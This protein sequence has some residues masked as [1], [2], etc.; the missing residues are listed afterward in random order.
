MDKFQFEQTF[1]EY[2]K[3]ER[4][5]QAA[6]ARALHVSRSTVSKWITGENRVAYETLFEI[7]ELLE[8]SD[9]ER[10]DFFTLAGYEFFLHNQESAPTQIASPYPTLHAE[11]KTYD[12]TLYISPGN[13]HKP[14]QLIGRDSQITQLCDHLVSGDHVLLTGYGGTG[15]TAL[16]ATVADAR[17]EATGK[18]VLWLGADGDDVESF[19]EALLAPFDAQ[20]EIA[21][22]RDHA[23][24]HAVQQ[25]LAS[26]DLALVVLDDLTHIN[27]L[28][29]LRP[30][31]PPGVPLLVTSRQ[32]AANI[33]RVVRLV[34]LQPA[35]AVN[36]LA[37]QAQ[38]ARFP[39]DEYASDPDT[40]RLC[41]LLGYHPLG[42]VI[43]GAWLKQ[44]GRAAGDLLRRID[45]A[46]ASA[47]TLEMPPGFAEA[48]RETV[49][50][51]LDQT[52]KTF[53]PKARGALRAF[54]SLHAPRATRDLLAACLGSESD[55]DR[56]A[57]DDALDELT[58][59]NFASRET[60]ED[61][62]SELLG[63]S[64]RDLPTVFTLHDMIYDYARLL[65]QRAPQTVTPLA[66][67]AQ[68]YVQASVAGDNQEYDDLKVNLPNVLRAAERADDATCLA[69]IAPI[70]IDGYMD[71]RGHRLDLLALLDRAIAYLQAQPAL[72]DAASRQLHHLLSKRGNAYFDRADYPN[73]VAAYR[74]ALELAYTFQREVM[75]IALV[76]KA[77]S[78][79][80]E[81]E[82]AEQHFAE[83]TGRAREA[84][85][86]YSLSF[87]L[88]QHAHVTIQ[89]E[90]YDHSHRITTEQ[91]AVNER[92]LKNEQ[93]SVAHQR[94]IF[95]LIMLGTSFIFGSKSKTSERQALEK[96]LEV[97]LRANQ[98][99]L[100]IENT[101][102]MAVSFWAVGDD[103]SRLGNSKRAEESFKLA[104]KLYSLQGKM[105]IARK[106]EHQILES[107]HRVK[108]RLMD[109]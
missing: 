42:L 26:A 52:L 13:L 47:L 29:Q 56:W 62:T 55:S 68:V 61:P 59:W 23:R 75:L 78:F 70:A 28:A 100:Q 95:S 102:A 12:A 103:Y 63:L 19:F 4:Y 80:G 81:V 32:D 43:A 109:M 64:A 24:T 21:D 3:R 96:A 93:S 94:L 92:I 85:D 37:G 87:V 77:L 58:A 44:H 65:H 53:S 101:H 20:S 39:R 67:A 33:D 34:N 82:A 72:D 69:L 22:K 25:T 107:N 6:L 15:K 83:A 50:F 35:A 54:G 73:A 46:P 45:G 108:E 51:T 8:L 11:R 91:V 74:A 84:G 89:C 17:I 14:S 104:Q 66:E 9:G 97:H 49:K 106:I 10:I 76:G 88:E 27:F 105:H 86:D 60:M 18:P 90:D 5:S 38:N 31:V 79:G 36:L 40:S 71:S 2:L 1:R 41:A 57:V 98:I 16:A 7:C 99:A 48:G 30:A